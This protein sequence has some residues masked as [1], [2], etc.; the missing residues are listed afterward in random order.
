MY[1]DILLKNNNSNLS[2]SEPSKSFDSMF[3]NLNNDIANVNDIIY[4]LKSKSIANKEEEQE[5]LEE[6]DKLNQDR[7]EFESYVNEKNAELRQKQEQINQYLDTQKKYLS[8]ANEEFK[9]NMQRSLMELD[10][11][12]K[13]LQIEKEKFMTEKDQFETYKKIEMESLHHSKDIFESEKV[14]FEKYKEICNKRIE[15]E[16]KSLEQKCSKFK[17]IIGEFNTNFKPLIDDKNE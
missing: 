12:R 5:L 2:T 4:N 14:Q 15:L 11:Q 17:N 16:T 1:D 8:S 10:I 3:N 9:T 6:R 7:V 13:E